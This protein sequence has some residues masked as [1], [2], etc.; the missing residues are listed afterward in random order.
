MQNPPQKYAIPQT[1]LNQHN[2]PKIEKANKL[3]MPK[4]SKKYNLFCK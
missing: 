1:L 4:E 2:P 3:N